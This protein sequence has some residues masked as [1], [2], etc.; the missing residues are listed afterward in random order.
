MPLVHTLIRPLDEDLPTDDLRQLRFRL[1]PRASVRLSAL[2][3]AIP[4]IFSEHLAVEA[5]HSAVA[6]E[7]DAIDK[8]AGRE[9]GEWR[10]HLAVARPAG[11]EVN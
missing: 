2:P 4:V 5:Q 10:E 8:A 3:E 6:E 11:H 1:G 9:P 7:L